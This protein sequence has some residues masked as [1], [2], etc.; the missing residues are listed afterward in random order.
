ML[1]AAISPVDFRDKKP[2]FLHALRRNMSHEQ[3]VRGDLAK[4]S[5][6]GR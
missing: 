2:H 3:T 6:S 5:R 1:P 4:P